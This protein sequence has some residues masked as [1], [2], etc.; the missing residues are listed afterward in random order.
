[1][2]LVVSF[3]HPHPGNENLMFNIESGNINNK[4]EADYAI[5]CTYMLNQIQHLRVD[6]FLVA[7]HFMWL[8]S[9]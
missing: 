3:H 8:S 4:K 9:I 7:F 5:I 6:L 1:M 2:S